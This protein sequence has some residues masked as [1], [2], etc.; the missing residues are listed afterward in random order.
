[1]SVA[2][3]NASLRV[4]GVRTV[5]YQSERQLKACVGHTVRITS[6]SMCALTSGKYIHVWVLIPWGV[7]NACV[8]SNVFIHVRTH[9]GTAMD[10]GVCTVGI[11]L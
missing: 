6:V 1:M 7:N 4:G 10:R 9:T 3:T 11:L 2:R 5:I 8:A